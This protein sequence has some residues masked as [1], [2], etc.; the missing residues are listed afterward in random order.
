MIQGWAARDV[1]ALHP[2]LLVRASVLTPPV[3][4]ISHWQL[5]AV[6]VTDIVFSH[7]AM[8]CPKLR[9]FPEGSQ[10]PRRSVRGYKGQTPLPLCGTTVRDFAT[11]RTP[12]RTSESLSCYNIL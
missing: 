6:S 12:Q 9:P 8:P 10:E 5:T 3:A 1:M 4:N 2:D 11:F 7:R